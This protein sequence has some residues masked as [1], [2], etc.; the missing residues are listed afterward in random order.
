MLCM[1]NDSNEGER[2]GDIDNSQF[3]QTEDVICEKSNDQQQQKHEDELTK[4]KDQ[5]TS[6]VPSLFNPFQSTVFFPYPMY[7]IEQNSNDN[8]D[9]GLLPSS[10]LDQRCS[11]PILS[12]A[13]TIN[14]T[15]R[16]GKKVVFTYVCSWERNCIKNAFH[17]A[18]FI[19]RGQQ[20]SAHTSSVAACVYWIKHPSRNFK[21]FLSKISHYQQ[22]QRRKIKGGGFDQVYIN[23]FPGSWCI[24]RKD[25]MLKCIQ[26]AQY[27]YSK[28]HGKSSAF[29]FLP[30]TVLII[31][32]ALNTKHSKAVDQSRK[33]RQMEY[34]EHQIKDFISLN[35]SHYIIKPCANSQGRGIQLI[36]V[37]KS[38]VCNSSST[39][40]H[41]ILSKLRKSSTYKKSTSSPSSFILQKYIPN[42]YLIDGLKFDLRLYVLVTSFEPLV[43]YIFQEGLVRFA[44]CQYTLSKREESNR[45]VH[46]TNY[47]IQKKYSEKKE[48][49]KQGN[50]SNDEK[51]NLRMD[52]TDHQKNEKNQTFSSPFYEAI[53][54]RHKCSL[55]ELWTHLE[56]KE[57]REKVIGCKQNIQDLIIKSLIA[58]DEEI[59]STSQQHWSRY[60]SSSCNCS[61]KSTTKSDFRKKGHKKT[62]KNFHN[63]SGLDNGFFELFGVDILLDR[64]L[65]PFLLEFN[66]A[67]SLMAGSSLLDK[68][69]KGILLSDT[70]HLVGISSSASETFSS[71]N[72]TIDDKWKMIYKLEDEYTRRGNF[73]RIFPTPCKSC[74]SGKDRQKNKRKMNKDSCYLD[75]FQTKRD[76]DR[77]VHDWLLHGRSKYN[78]QIRRNQ[79]EKN[80]TQQQSHQVRNII[81]GPIGKRKE[82]KIYTQ[83]ASTEN[84][85]HL[86]HPVFI[87]HPLDPICSEW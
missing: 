70:L 37:S 32:P 9:V 24:G 31:V 3:N 63:V 16:G 12:T 35:G 78:H 48:N 67:P 57:G 77:I 8:V 79:L 50:E 46:L 26:R 72:E 64:Q 23:H 45:F 29:D 19:R 68:K 13:T 52:S 71:N 80:S 73:F 40:V 59:T 20:S 62:Y 58:S 34:L 84:V 39:I 75:Y 28:N 53:H 69:I 74:C 2:C 10:M 49:M 38:S 87:N 11:D 44:S 17:E 76:N 65:R 18:G 66:I 47:S 6:F 42:P 41:D 15:D 83:Q 7:L 43:S 21:S 25:R 30:N 81:Q 51:E 82:S 55:T 60:L 14:G 54:N 36:S 61:S 86:P 27:T 56:E 5:I 22:K 85:D 33:K 4:E 1:M